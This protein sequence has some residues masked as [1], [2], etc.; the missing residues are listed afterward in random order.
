M[1]GV[2]TGMSELAVCRKCK[3]PICGSFC[4]YW[5]ERVKGKGKE[6]I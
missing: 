4:R 6:C 5:V 1:A 3:R 2:D